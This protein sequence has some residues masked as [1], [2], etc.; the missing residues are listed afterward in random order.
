MKFL[1]IALLFTFSINASQAKTFID[2]VTDVVGSSP[3]VNINLGTGI[4][5]TILSLSGDDDAKEVRKIIAGLDKIRISV[6]NID[7]NNNTK[8]LGQLIKSKIK[9]MAAQG[10]EQIVTIKEDHESVYIIAKVNDQY[11]QDA[12]II[13]MEEGDELVILSMEG[14]LDL[15]Q[16]AQVSDHFDVDIGGVTDI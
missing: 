12:M 1:T 16:L 10:Y 8:R 14:E 6:F 9:N 5:N 7:G 11:L 2:E 4:I 3:D 15:K 13:V